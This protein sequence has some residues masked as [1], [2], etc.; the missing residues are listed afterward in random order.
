MYFFYKYR[1][2]PNKLQVSRIDHFM[3]AYRFT[4]NYFVGVFKD[5]FINRPKKR[6]Y[7][8]I[9]ANDYLSQLTSLIKQKSWLKSIPFD[10]LRQALYE[11]GIDFFNYTRVY[12]HS[13][14][15]FPP[16]MKKKRFPYKFK[17]IYGNVDFNKLTVSLPKIGKVKFYGNQRIDSKIKLVNIT[18]RNDGK[19]YLEIAIKSKHHKSKPAEID[20]EHSVGIDVGLKDFAV[21]SNGQVFEN[22]RFYEKNKKKIESL[23]RKLYRQKKG[24]NRWKITNNR[25]I[26]LNNKINNS[27]IDY[28]HKASS[29]IVRENQTII[30]ECLDIK[31][32][33]KDIH[34]G[35]SIKEIRWDKFFEF[36]KYKCIIYGKNLIRINRYD[37]SSKTC[38]CGYVYKDLS[39]SER[40]WICPKCGHNNDRD[41]LAA[42]NIKKFG[43]SG[44][45]R[46]I[47]NESSSLYD[48]RITSAVRGIEDVEWT[49]VLD[50]VKRQY[51]QL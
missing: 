11:A 34:L 36:L 51:V 42:I 2:K 12:S 21:L 23:K 29:M 25:L 19:Y 16:F 49:K 50:T 47:S 37:A 33:K 39:L 45:R 18:K 17:S 7:P 32:M 24:S 46:L 41:M 13:K 3:D 27:Y 28:I 5:V 22:K 20:I 26:K 31:N 43:L 8:D 30:I 38:L 40:E 35:K 9:N 1:L 44:N 4:Y 48:I 6:E 14:T 10:Y 15:K